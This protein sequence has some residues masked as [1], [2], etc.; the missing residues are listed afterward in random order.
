MIG[1]NDLHRLP[2][3]REW[4]VQITVSILLGLSLLPAL[5]RYSGLSPDVASVVSWGAL[6]L[7]LT[8]VWAVI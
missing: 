4:I 1:L 2:Q 5:S 7:L 6:L 3:L 8:L